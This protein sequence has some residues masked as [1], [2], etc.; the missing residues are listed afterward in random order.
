MI[1][2]LKD[3][4]KSERKL[5]KAIIQI[6]LNCKDFKTLNNALIYEFKSGNLKGNRPKKE[7]I[8]R[9]LKIFR[10]MNPKIS[11]YIYN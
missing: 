9:R 3:V 7:E 11:D 6:A 10:E 4:P 2:T 1:L 5:N 8:K